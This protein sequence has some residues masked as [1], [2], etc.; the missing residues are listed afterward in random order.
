MK[1]DAKYVA[2]PHTSL[3][4]ANIYKIPIYTEKNI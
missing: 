4:V 3:F 2:K 1:L